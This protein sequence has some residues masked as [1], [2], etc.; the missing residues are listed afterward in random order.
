MKLFNSLRIKDVVTLIWF[1]YF[2]NLLFFHNGDYDFISVVLL[3]QL[4]GL[5]QHNLRGLLDLGRVLYFNECH[6]R[7]IAA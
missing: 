4:Y 5:N 1:L 3:A 6:F 7:L 2:I